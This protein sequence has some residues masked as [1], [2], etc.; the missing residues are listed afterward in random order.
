[1]KKSENLI[2]GIAIEYL[3]S[4]YVLGDTPVFVNL[5]EKIKR[6]LSSIDQTE[7]VRY[8]NELLT[9]FQSES[10]LNLDSLNSVLTTETSE[11]LFRDV[12]AGTPGAI[13]ALIKV[14]IESEDVYFAE[15]ALSY[16]RGHRESLE[17]FNPSLQIDLDFIHHPVGL[18]LHAL[19]LGSTS[20]ALSLAYANFRL[21]VENR[22]IDPGSQALRNLGLTQDEIDLLC[23]RFGN[24]VGDL[25]AASSSLR[26]QLLN[27]DENRR[28][29]EL[30]RL[31]TNEHFLAS[32]EGL[33]YFFMFV[34][35]PAWS[36]L[37]FFMS[38][39]EAYIELKKLVGSLDTQVLTD[40][41]LVH[42]GSNVHLD[43][44]LLCTLSDSLLAKRTSEILDF[45]GLFHC[46]IDSFTI[47]T[48]FNPD[49]VHWNGGIS[50]RSLP[51]KIRFLNSSEANR[52]LYVYCN[53]AVGTKV[54]GLTKNEV[55]E[56]DSSSRL[57]KKA[58]NMESNPPKNSLP[59][60]IIDSL[61]RFGEYSSKKLQGFSELD[62]DLIAVSPAS[63][64]GRL[65][66][67]NPGLV[68]SN[69]M[70]ST[71][72]AS[73]LRGEIEEDLPKVEWLPSP[74]ATLLTNEPVEILGVEF[75]GLIGNVLQIGYLINATENGF[76][77]MGNING[78][79]SSLA[80]ITGLL[81][82]LPFE[83]EMEWD[84]LVEGSLLNVPGTALATDR[85]QLDIAEYRPCAVAL[86]FYG[87]HHANLSIVLN[88]AGALQSGSGNKDLAIYLFDAAS[89]CGQPNALSSLTWEL[90]AAGHADLAI[91][92]FEEYRKRTLEHVKLI[93]VSE[94]GNR[95]IED[96]LDMNHLNLNES[97]V[98][99]AL[100][101]YQSQLAN[102]SGNVGLAYHIAG[103][104]IA[105]D[106]N[107]TWASEHGHAEARIY[108]HA[109][110]L[111]K[112]KNSKYITVPWLTRIRAA[113]LKRNP[114][115][116][117]AK[118]L[119]LSE[120]ETESLIETIEEICSW[121]LPELSEL[122]GVC[123]ELL[124]AL[125]PTEKRGAIVGRNRIA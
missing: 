27:L 36:N 16:L 56:S 25:S 97:A 24:L 92:A 15:K 4:C 96:F 91:R 110:E 111:I 86:P 107:W 71:E 117:L 69:Q 1:M 85:L 51:I 65:S 116:V 98:P 28:S 21:K 31:L 5:A 114:V 49:S 118:R 58:W 52:Q 18:L 67:F 123:N 80:D 41:G 84:E 11:K 120:I 79:I 103:D 78:A 95:E 8:L 64:I 100:D 109:L 44:K 53:V 9:S 59:S 29:Q 61:F 33:G 3:N 20:A 12:D 104:V 72:L 54:K 48:A 122:M 40:L 73:A 30:L 23:L 75:P 13:R 60:K 93:E 6:L 106:E 89:A 115:E 99:E 112:Q 62:S 124:T 37:G 45:L 83:A 77:L 10:V 68:S 66:R 119:S 46:A 19:D 17:D 14:A 74:V 2:K 42:P 82:N 121:N 90:L 26:K 81:N 57:Q 101:E 88:D 102:A 22:Q 94:L 39:N 38:L 87:T 43:D 34:G 70:Y 63:Q 50:A 108:R 105:R 76:Y 125:A 55:E 35:G 113:L 47:R 32:R 7:E